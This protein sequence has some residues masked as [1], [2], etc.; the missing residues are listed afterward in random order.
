MVLSWRQ[1]PM[2]Q[3][4]QSR[5]LDEF[6]LRKPHWCLNTLRPRQNGRHFP[7]YIFKC[8]FLNENVWLSLKI[9]LK[10]VAEGPINNIPA[11]VQKMAW[12][13]PGDKPLSEAMVGSLL[14][15]IR[16][17]RPQWVDIAI[18]TCHHMDITFEKLCPELIEKSLAIL[19]DQIV[20]TSRDITWNH[21][22]YYWPFVGNYR[23]PLDSP[24]ID[25][26]AMTSFEHQRTNA[27]TIEWPVFWNAMSIMW[28][29]WNETGGKRS[30]QKLLCE[31]SAT[32]GPFKKI[33]ELWNFHMWVKYISLYVW[34]GYFVWDLNGTFEIQHKVSYPCI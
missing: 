18:T 14:T 3:L 20:M 16:V 5:H 4:P 17:T 10:F 24:H 7:D 27:Q 1:P 26:P 8:I 25:G 23:S 6:D 2:Q 21:M 30:T 22:P 11:L 32:R 34:A 19:P 31:P 33:E 9:S 28:R 12:R 13:L 29:H 15:R